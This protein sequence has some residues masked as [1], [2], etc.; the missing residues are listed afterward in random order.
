MLARKLLLLAGAA[1][2]MLGGSELAT[3]EAGP[4][5]RAAGVSVSPP[6]SVSPSHDYY[7]RAEFVV[8]IEK[9]PSSR[10]WVTL[11][12]QDRGYGLISIAPGVPHSA[13]SGIA[14]LNTGRKRRA[15]FRFDAPAPEIRVRGLLALQAVAVLDAEPPPDPAPLVAPAVNIRTPWQLVTTAGADASSPEGLPETLATMRNL[16]PLMRALGFN[17]IESYVKWN[18]VERSPGRFDWSFYDAVVDEIE[19]HGLRWFP[20]LIA[21]SA[22]TLPDWYHDS[23]E[24]AGFE[25]LEHH[26]RNDIQSIFCDNQRK[27]VRR[28]L[29]EFGKHYGGRKALLGIRLGPSGNYGEAQY[30]ARGDLGYQGRPIHTHIGYWAAGPYA[31]ASFRAWLRSRYASVEDLN[32]A[33]GDRFPSFDDVQ[34]FLPVTAATQRKR[35]DFATWYMDSMSRWCEQWAEWAREALPGAVIHQSSGGWGPI[36]IGTDYSYQARTMARLKGGIRL[37]NE[38]DNFVDN[39]GITRMASSAARFYGASLGYEP[40]GFGSARGVVARLF[41]AITN[42]AEHLFYYHPNLTD[43]DQGVDAWLRYA[44][45]LDRRARPV[46]DV[47]LFYPDTAIKLDD[48]LVRYRWGSIFFLKAQ[49]LRGVLDYDYLSEQMIADG[50]LDRYKALVF[51]WGHI[52]E[53]PVLERIARWVEAGGTLIYPPN[54]RGLLGTVEGDTRIAQAWQAGSTGKGKVIFFPGD[55]APGEPYARFVGE[56]LSKLDSLRPE[57]RQALRIRKPAWV[58]WSLLENHALMLL[59]FSDDEALAALPGGNTVQLKPYSIRQTTLVPE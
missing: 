1:V 55:P 6:G 52:T 7:R 36:E 13:Q 59:N 33:W 3:W 43:N 34:T 27:Y 54:P 49:A 5:P 26:L 17:G 38:S 23:P 30:P 48:E 22:Y 12:Y 50:A 20:L 9:P 31:G 41:N 35:A 51:V 19:K 16:L 4:P 53:K 39:F 58:Y 28:F 42:G 44:P 45:L 2:G 32:K 21:G 46:I 8:R 11:T 47:A 57:V 15:T 10:Y 56:E 25:C 18:F 40:G 29:Q 37:T 24:N 14:R